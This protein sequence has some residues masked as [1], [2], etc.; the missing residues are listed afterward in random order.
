MPVFICQVFLKIFLIKIFLPVYYLQ[1]ISQVYCTRNRPVSDVSQVRAG[2]PATEFLEA[3]TLVEFCGAFT[4]LRLLG[5]RTSPDKRKDGSDL[6]LIRLFSNYL[7]ETFSG[8][9]IS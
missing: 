4:V 2:L 9:F 5:I 7:I 6:N 3:Y 8:D 1:L